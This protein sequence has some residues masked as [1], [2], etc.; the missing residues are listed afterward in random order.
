MYLHN[1]IM[2]NINHYSITK[3]H[4]SGNLQINKLPQNANQRTQTHKSFAV[5]FTPY[6]G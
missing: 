5:Y 4:K 6:F 3:T 1:T 2:W